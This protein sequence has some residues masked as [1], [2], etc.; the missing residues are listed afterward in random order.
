MDE[1]PSI[2]RLT[3]RRAPA[4]SVIIGINLVVFLLWYL[5]PRFPALE[6]FMV[7]NFLVGTDHLREGYWWTLLTSVF[8]HAELWHLAI[9]M[10]VLWSFGMVLEQFWGSRTFVTFYLVAGVVGS[11]CH[12][13]ASE[14]LMKEKGIPA[15]GAS[16]AVSGLLL[17]YA[18]HFPRAKILLFGIIPMPALVG[19]LAFVGI[20]VWG[21][22]E[23]SQGGGFSIGH[24]AH[25]G[26]A[27]A[28]LLIWAFYLRRRYVPRRAPRLSQAEAAE[29]ERIIAKANRDGPESLSFDEQQFVAD[30]QRR[31]TPR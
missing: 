19:V 2:L 14:Y 24:G 8:S 30:I 29:F 28:G 17:A 31:L 15:L 10:F 21:L 12:C 18:L 1:R 22:V 4:V 7:Y 6:K 20:D 27:L 23:Q 11:V 26:G 5:A 16:G 9:N 3:L 25:L 13:L